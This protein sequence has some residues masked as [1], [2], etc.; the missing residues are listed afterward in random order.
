MKCTG[1]NQNPVI[2]INIIMCLIYC[3]GLVIHSSS[4]VMSTA[5]PTFDFRDR[6]LT[7]ES[8]LPSD[9]VIVKQSQV[10]KRVLDLDEDMLTQYHEETI[11]LTISRERESKK[12]TKRLKTWVKLH[13]SEWTSC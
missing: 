11:E 7:S 2:H 1:R 13:K 12:Q 5:A 3:L 4:R 9:R 10:T 6:A 8:S